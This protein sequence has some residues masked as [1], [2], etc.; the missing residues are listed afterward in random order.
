MGTLTFESA[1]YVARYL[2][3]K[4]LGKNKDSHYERVDLETGEIYWLHPEYAR[5]SR[6]PGLGTEWYKRH[7]AEAARHD[8]VIVNEKE[9]LPPKFYESFLSEEQLEH[10]KAQR[11]KQAKK[12]EKE[13]TTARLRVR[14]HVKIAATQTLKRT[15]E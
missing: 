2:M 8:S 15:I 3:K 12:F 4:A 6:R 10:T 1:A 13:S 7:G 14:E 11:R 5:M 9:V